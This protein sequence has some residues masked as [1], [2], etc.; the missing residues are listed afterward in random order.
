MQ[1]YLMVTFQWKAVECYEENGPIT[2]YHYRVYYDLFNFN[3]GI[4]DRNT[5]MVSLIYNNMQGFSVAAMNEAGTGEHCPPVQVHNF[6][7]GN[8]NL[9]KEKSAL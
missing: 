2:G 6:D 5:T 9:K 1:T 7:E 3:D 8:E 4:V